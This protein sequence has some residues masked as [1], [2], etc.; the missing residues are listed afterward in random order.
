MAELL[1]RL[2]R[3]SAQ[4]AWR[5]VVGWIVILAAAAGA[6]LGFGGTLATGFNI[7]GTETER[8]SAQLADTFPELTGASASVVFQ[9][10]DGTKFT[11]E[12]Q[13]GVADLLQEVGT[14]DGVASTTDP[15]TMTAMREQPAPDTTDQQV[16]TDP[17]QLENAKK[18]AEYGSNFRVISDDGS[19]AVGLV[20]FNDSMFALTDELTAQGRAVLD[21][22]DIAGVTVDYSSTI[23]T[24]ADGIFGF[25][26]VAG[27]IIAALVLILMM[28]AFLPMVTPLISSI[29]GVGTGV[30]GSMAFS[31]VFEMTIVT[32]VLAVML[33]LAVGIDY[34]L[35]ILNR[36]RRQL[37]TGMS[38]VDSI[39]LANGTAGNAVVFAGSTVVLALV[40]L[41]VTGIPA[42]TGMGI[43][44]G[45]SVTIAVLIAVTFTPAVLGLMGLRA[46][47]K[48][49]RANITNSANKT[50]TTSAVTPMSTG[51]AILIAV[52]TAAALLV[53]AIPALSMRLGLPDGSSE[54]T[55]TTQYRAAKIIDQEFGPGQNGPLLVVA[56]TK[57]PVAP[58]DQ[59]TAQV[60]MAT[61]IHDQ[62]HVSAVAPVAISDDCTVF[63]FQVVPDEGP[64]SES[65]Q[66]LVHDLRDLTPVSLAG[67]DDVTI[68]V[69]GT[70]SG[71]IDISEKL[72]DA[73]PIYLTVVIGLSLLIMI[74]VFRSILVPVI[75]TAGYILS[76][77][78]A[79][80]TV[81]A[82]F[83]FGWFSSLF[84]VHDPGPVLS[85]AP[86]IIMGVLFGLAMDYQL[87]LVSGMR[88][89]FIHGDTARQAVVAGVHAGRTV[90]TAAAIIMIAV[91][92]GFIFSEI[93]MIRP[94]GMGLATGVL[95]DAFIVRLLLIPALMHL[96][97]TTAWWLPKWLERILPNVDVEGARLERTH[98]THQ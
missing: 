93:T 56:T 17:A 91:L 6:F 64:S 83:Q 73:L 25:G 77:F 67:Q 20:Q 78:A 61:T 98:T 53:I 38:P 87:F 40:A 82:I 68:G 90:V 51:R 92:G 65:T 14:I 59:M 96:F 27:L 66:Q 9:T 48:K 50:I 72:S 37:R 54:P 10:A 31:D 39:A 76:L 29:I 62:E 97:G 84:G 89:A 49:A 41:V 70:A 74:V 75:A 13:H 94:L 80:G 95:F 15:F 88:E 55:D 57:A 43:V 33:G 7:P 81:T 12:Q 28:R 44:G 16:P 71:N 8:V 26:E 24:S 35:F 5:V 2:G 69:A 22:A 4:H 3:W 19:T 63:A 30:A 60:D 79:L 36:H 86:I 45:V 11:A 42:V 32:P 23:I 1:F 47:P 85:F 21:D 58:A 18:L 46:L 52:L 34:S